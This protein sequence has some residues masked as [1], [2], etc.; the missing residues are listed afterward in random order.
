MEGHEDRA[1]TCWALASVAAAADNRAARQG[2]LQ[3]H[4]V[5]DGL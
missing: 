4:V 1:A 5:C 3:R 2:R